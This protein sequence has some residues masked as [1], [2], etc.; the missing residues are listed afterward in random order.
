[1]TSDAPIDPRNRPFSFTVEFDGAVHAT[2]Q[3]VTGLEAEF[4]IEEILEGGENRFTFRLPSAPQPSAMP[5]TLRRGFAHSQEF[6]DWLLQ[7]V[8]KGPTVQL[9][10]LSIFMMDVTDQERVAGWY[11][12][13][14][15]PSQ[16]ER[17]SPKMSDIG[18]AVETLTFSYNYF[19]RL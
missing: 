7:A 5:I 1:M 19:G 3:E 17:P 6:L 2:F 14:A 9:K 4:T 18:V 13:D 15:W 11:V 12:S 10:N 16:L 8:G